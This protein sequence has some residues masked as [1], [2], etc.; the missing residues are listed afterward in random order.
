[1]CCYYCYHYFKYP[2]HLSLILSPSPSKHTGFRNQQKRSSFQIINFTRFTFHSSRF[3]PELCT[4][5]YK[6]NGE[7]CLNR[8]INKY[9]GTMKQEPPSTSPMLQTPARNLTKLSIIRNSE[10]G[11]QEEKKNFQNFSCSKTMSFLLRFSLFSLM[12]D[13]HSGFLV[14]ARK[15]L[16]IEKER[17]YPIHMPHT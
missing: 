13:V 8:K 9:D 3:A 1:M 7:K 4:Y 10:R 14:K 2:C 15:K 17:N 6:L 5:I 11:R 16:G 12:R